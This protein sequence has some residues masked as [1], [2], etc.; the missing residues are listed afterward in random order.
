M[1][2]P[3]WKDDWNL[4][5]AALYIANVTGTAWNGS[6]SILQGRLHLPRSV[7]Q[8]V[9]VDRRRVWGGQI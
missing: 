2:L 4:V 8:C 5:R 1:A 3:N 7:R 9:C 6:W